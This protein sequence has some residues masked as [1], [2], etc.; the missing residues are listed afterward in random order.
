MVRGTESGS[1]VGGCRRVIAGCCEYNGTPWPSICLLLMIF[2]AGKHSDGL[3]DGGVQT[4]VQTPEE[5]RK[6]VLARRRQYLQVGA[7]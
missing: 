1:G 2:A 7:W 3:A 4:P 5:R 6:A